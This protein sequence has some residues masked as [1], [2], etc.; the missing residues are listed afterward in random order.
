MI[1]SHT[2]CIA[3]NEL[4]SEIMILFSVVE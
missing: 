1:I 3:L 4:A 2:A